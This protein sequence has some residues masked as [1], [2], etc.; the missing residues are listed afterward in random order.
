H[1]DLVLVGRIAAEHGRASERVGAE[2]AGRGA[3]DASQRQSARGAL[4]GAD[5]RTSAV[6]VVGIDMAP[7]ERHLPRAGFVHDRSSILAAVVVTTGV[8]IVAQAVVVPADRATDREAGDAEL[9][10]DDPLAPRR[11]VGTGDSVGV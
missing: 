8:V 6:A 5:K 10:A 4:R 7:A 2:V 1:A 11:E 3:R 9:R